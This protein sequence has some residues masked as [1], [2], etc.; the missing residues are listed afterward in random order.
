[1]NAIATQ[2]AEALANG[3][4]HLGD[5]V[6]WS[7]SGASPRHQTDVAAF[8]HGIDGDLKL[9][10]VNPAGAYRTALRA[11]VT[12]AADERRWSVTL[13]EE[14]S[15]R[16]VHAILAAEEVADATTLSDKTREFR[17]STKV[18]FNKGSQRLRNVNY[19]DLFEAEDAAHPVAIRA[20]QEYAALVECYR[21]EDLRSA[22]Q[23]A[24][25]RWAG[26]RLVDTGGVWFIPAE[27]A[28]K[29]RAWAEFM[30]KLGHG[31]LVLPMFDS[32]EAVA[33]LRTSAQQSLEGQLQQIVDDLAQFAGAETTRLSTLEERLER[34]ERLQR[35]AELYQRLLGV[36]TDELG[37]GLESARTALNAAITGWKPR[38]REKK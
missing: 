21:T 5:V 1:M 19:I 32:R 20:R 28:T 3:G 33:N 24:F 9:P 8:A 27:Y 11:A 10:I 23:T 16:I 26:M 25:A 34:W 30:T 36:R 14:T 37:K 29:V 22:F 4:R 2:L 15:Q 17:T 6:G 12:G 38:K 31:T 13:V 35:D 7:Q 18:A